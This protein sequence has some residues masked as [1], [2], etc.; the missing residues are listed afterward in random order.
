M[1]TQVSLQPSV[2]MLISFS[3]CST[4]QR[5]R[6]FA[7]QRMVGAANDRTLGGRGAQ[8]QLNATDAAVADVAAAT[9]ERV[10]TAAAA[11]AQHEHAGGVGVR[12]EAAHQQRLPGRRAA[13]HPTRM[14]WG[15]GGLGCKSTF[16][17]VRGGMG[18]GQFQ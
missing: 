1:S 13:P 5:I 7:A 14:H 17:A 4:T 2:P 6:V 16:T 12:S 11:A 3:S 15:I 9:A 18:V 8:L 10:A